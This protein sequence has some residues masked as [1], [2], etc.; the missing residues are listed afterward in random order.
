MTPRVDREGDGNSM[1]PTVPI[2]C[3]EPKDVAKAL[4]LLQMLFPHRR[5]AGERPVYP[6]N[7]PAAAAVGAAR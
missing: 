6:V 4:P 3:A 7:K 2:A 5:L 1:R